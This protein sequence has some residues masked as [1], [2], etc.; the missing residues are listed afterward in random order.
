MH[1]QLIVSALPWVPPR[2]PLFRLDRQLLIDPHAHRVR[3]VTLEGLNR[4]VK[5]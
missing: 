4:L 2:A 5:G 3:R 1:P